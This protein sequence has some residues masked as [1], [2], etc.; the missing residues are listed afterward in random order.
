MIPVATAKTTTKMSTEPAISTLMEARREVTSTSPT[1][2]AKSKAKQKGEGIDCFFRNYHRGTYDE[3][4]ERLLGESR[5][6]EGDGG[7]AEE[8]RAAAMEDFSNWVE[9]CPS[10]V[11]LHRQNPIDDLGAFESLYQ[12]LKT[13]RVQELYM[14]ECNIG[15]DMDI[16]S[17]VLNTNLTTSIHLRNNNIGK[18]G[19]D[20]I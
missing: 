12:A 5:V 20:E 6:P 17:I 14:T 11:S 9:N 1:A 18:A 2:T 8:R 10:V 4:V 7:A 19:A 13:G 3:E 15:D 16:V